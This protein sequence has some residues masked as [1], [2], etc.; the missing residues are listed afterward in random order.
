MT[1]DL[2]GLQADDV[3][4]NP[5]RVD[6][7]DALA[8][9]F[10]PDV[11]V[12]MLPVR[13][14]T[15]FMQAE[16]RIPG[17]A[18]TLLDLAAL[19]DGATHPI[20]L[21]AK[22]AL[23]TSL[24]GKTGSDRDTF[25]STTEAELYAFVT[26][27]LDAARLAI[28]EVAKEARNTH[29]PGTGGEKRLLAGIA[30]HREALAAAG[31][32]IA[33]LRS[34]Y[35]R[36]HFT[37]ALKEL[38]EATEPV[39]H[40]LEFETLPAA[41]LRGAFKSRVAPTAEGEPDPDRAGRGEVVVPNADVA[42]GAARF[43][44]LLRGIEAGGDDPVTVEAL[45]E[46]ATTIPLLPADWKRKLIEAARNLDERTLVAD[47]AGLI[48]AVELIRS[49]DLVQ[50]RDR[51]DLGGAVTIGSSTRIEDRLVVRIYPD[52]LAVDT[53]EEALTPTEREAGL[54]Y[55]RA[56]LAAA[57]DEQRR[58][59]WRALCLGRGSRRAAWIARELT[60]VP[61]PDSP[62][63]VAASRATR[64]L[65]RLDRALEQMGLRRSGK[66]AALAD[67]AEVL[68]NHLDDAEEMPE[69]PLAGLRERFALT[70]QAVE[71][72]MR[73]RPI[74][75]LDP[76]SAK[77]LRRAR[78]AIRRASQLVE[79]M[80][81][82]PPP[83]PVFPDAGTQPKD[84]PWTRAA[85]AGALPTR[86]LVVAV[87][88]GQVAHAV[89]GLDVDP[90]LS[91]SIDP[92]SDQ[93]P[94]STGGFALDEATGELHVADS[95]RWM[96]D[97]E[98]AHR[99]GMAVT[100]PITMDE[101]ASGFDRVY[102]IGLCDEVAA[103]GAT[104]LES[105]LNNHH[106]GQ[107]G[108]ELLPVGTS[109]NNTEAGGAGFTSDDDPDASFD[110]E[111]GT[112]KIT[113]SSSTG[114]EAPDGVRLARALGVSLSTLEHVEGADGLRTTEAQTM[115][116]ALYAA[117]LGG[118]LEEHAAT[119][120]PPQARRRL[121]SLARGHVAARGLV[122][123][124]RVGRQPYG[125]LPTTAWSRFVP[126]HDDALDPAVRGLE[127]TQQAQFDDVLK[128]MLDV[129][130]GDWSR[131]RAA[132]VRRANDPPPHVPGTADGARSHFLQVLGL[133]AVASGG[134]SRFGV[135]VAGRHGPPGLDPSLQ[136]GLP[137]ASGGTT[138]AAQ[139]GPFALLD[140][141]D[142]VLRSAY[143]I[144]STDPLRDATG[145]VG[146]AMADVYERLVTA[147]AYELR[148]F[149][150]TRALGGP[151]VEA[152]PAPALS[153]L[154]SQP[155]ISLIDDAWRGV[156]ELV[157]AKNPERRPPLR[158]LLVLLA[159]HARLA[160]L[161]DTALDLLV[162]KGFL[163][164]L[165]RM[166]I[167]SSGHYFTGGLNPPTLTGWTY[168]LHPLADLT[169]ASSS[170]NPP[171][172]S[173]GPLIHRLTVPPAEAEAELE[174]YV[175]RVASHADDLMELAALPADRLEILLGEQLD[176]AS[177]RLDA[178]ITAFS[179]R[180]LTSLRGTTPRGAHLAA[181]G[182]LDDLRPN[183]RLPLA[184]GVPASLA[185]PS[186]PI[187][188]DQTSQGFVHAPSINH[189]V[190]A[191]ILRSG[192]ISQHADRDVQN[193]MAVNL[194]SRRTRVGLSLI[195]GV[196]AGNTL[197]AL[198]GYRLE[199]FL[200]ES[201]DRGGP[202]L[203]ALIGPL[204]A[205]YPTVVAVDGGT[206]T[207]TAAAARQ[208]CDGLKI[209]D[210]VQGWIA[211]TPGTAVGGT[212]AD[213]LRANLAARPWMLSASAVPD[214]AQPS[215]TPAMLDGLILAI[216]HIADAMDALADLVVAE[217][218]HQLARGNHAR[219][220]AVLS[221][222][223]EGKA[224]PRPELVDTP[225]TGT[226]LVHRVLLHLPD[227][228]TLGGGWEEIPLTPR[229][230]CEPALNA[231][232]ATLLGDPETLRVRVVE[233][234]TGRDHQRTPGTVGVSA[235]DLQLQP[236]DLVA[237]LGSG[238]ETGLGELAV[239][240]LD[241]CRPLELDDLAPPARCEVDRGR[242]PAWGADVR[243]VF[244]L[245]PLLESL[246]GL[247]G[248]ARPAS[249][250]DYVLATPATEGEGDGVDTAELAG[251]IATAEDAL[252]Q[253]AIALAELLSGRAPVP[254]AELQ[255]DPRRW[256]TALP[257][258]EL[259]AWAERELWRSAVLGA[260]AFGITAALPP[261]EFPDRVT[262]RQQLRSAAETAFIEVVDRLQAASDQLAGSPSVRD[263]LAAAQALFGEA[264]VVVPQVSPANAAEVTTALGAEIASPAEI[265]G[266][267]QGAGMVREGAGVLADVLT[268]ADA[269]DVLLEPPAVA[270]LPHDPESP[271]A[272]IGGRVPEGVDPAGRLS[273]AVFGE[274]RSPGCALLV[275]EWTEIIPGDH[276]TTGVAVHYD[277]PDSTPPQCLLVAVPPERGAPW[278]IGTLVQTLHDTFELAQVRAVELEHLSG[279]LYGQLL[280]AISG[281]L[282]P[283]A[284]RQ[285]LSGFDPDRMLLDFAAIKG[286]S[287]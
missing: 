80:P 96:V 144:T 126:H 99:Q 102:A 89:A 161:R 64:A 267:L 228:T 221:A 81:V 271:E 122:P 169:W 257:A 280:P 145:Q 187:Y 167:G 181:Y 219:A 5:R 137:P 255:G 130:L 57:T 39:L 188:R 110:R 206:T 67:A 158:S 27:Q 2:T 247:V 115:G 97:L 41:S 244:E 237:I 109:T 78:A 177:H 285:T 12:V 13:L 30:A 242:A 282:L 23:A 101:A 162:D 98:E 189:A 281:E 121:K 34:D 163:T 132:K 104:R 73:R 234:A 199:R 197:G 72:L 29:D 168:L 239:R 246:G 276:E 171:F 268:L 272:W 118:W 92:A 205:A 253:V 127:R 141:F 166:A 241:A 103:D 220:A 165:G 26:E 79:A 222:L 71:A 90:N 151:F 6:E 60:P 182:W 140:H 283:D 66:L 174:P 233:A 265:E 54:A 17:P 51:P 190:T 223:A 213:I 229:A 56:T 226:P 215:T 55:W 245:A 52:D 184:T 14:E 227:G 50:G 100:V 11:P 53:H 38:A 32:S 254:E 224:P 21:V 274:A 249:A 277:Q 1:L 131:E 93:T 287:A 4:G 235:V 240:A 86:F 142:A 124:F 178:W 176:L 87:A 138:T 123:A 218:V 105:L 179:Q 48:N 31:D 209:L 35:Q 46:T 111:R 47:T 3:R 69:T 70:A 113:S 147:R 125:V 273:L 204:R 258:A 212:V 139:N 195:D 59:P 185:D 150:R 259:P 172:A 248:R 231:W 200:H 75:T 128:Q 236:I 180:R 201:H 256:L 269:A 120:I 243:T 210:V 146:A 7:I 164:D 203:D 251:R 84:G 160:E 225:R 63:T 250:H 24:E 88:G 156:G 262:V 263:Q 217:G 230:A 33:E 170:S 107:T 16:V 112:K 20:T 286:T 28:R 143:G 260:A 183:A 216:D 94:G 194:S 186:R 134:V 211:A 148:Y 159:R 116:R 76:D 275:D 198:L 261:A 117:T 91:L 65:E 196:R 214:P 193:R 284:V 85:A 192:Y 106:Y 43:G 155:A 15:R 232:L 108:L 18:P 36:E 129:M 135:N 22:Q 62:G 264:F 175:E 45:R 279:T 42:A 154:V 153:A 44:E 157:D 133:G 77:A 114:E 191:A 25:K 149:D 49:D 207:N 10:S 61:Q 37:G 266:W 58:S 152:D 95:I 252:V 83:A 40:Q 9:S 8:A 238:L 82:E 208:V 173:G 68:L 202:T 278:S 136:F 74:A 270:Q 19:L 119:L